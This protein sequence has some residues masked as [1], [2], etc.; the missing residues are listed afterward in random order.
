[1]K[2]A[3]QM[4][5]ANIFDVP[6]SSFGEDK[7]HKRDSVSRIIRESGNQLLYTLP[8]SPISNPIEQFFNQLKFHMKVT[9][10]MTLAALH[11]SVRDAVGK[12]RAENYHNYFAYAYDRMQLSRAEK[13]AS[14]KHR[15][16]KIYKP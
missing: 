5:W 6:T 14:T 16:P 4:F 12:V 2:S 13:G 8:Y 15:S 1:M 11:T 3:Y 10:A 9:R 7:I